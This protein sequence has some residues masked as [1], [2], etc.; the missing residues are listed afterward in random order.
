MQADAVHPLTDATQIGCSFFFA[1]AAAYLREEGGKGGGKGQ[2]EKGCINLHWLLTNLAK[3][4]AVKG[5]SPDLKFGK[6]R[7]IAC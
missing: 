6:F 2:E 1:R 3:S 4:P 5:K 7:F